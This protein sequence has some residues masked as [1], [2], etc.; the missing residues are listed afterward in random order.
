MDYMSSGSQLLGLG[1]SRLRFSRRLTHSDSMPS[2]PSSAQEPPDLLII[3]LG[4]ELQLTGVV[5]ILPEN[6]SVG[7]RLEAL[8]QERVD[9]LKG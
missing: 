8:L 6:L 5:K 2:E 7:R 9:V 1:W 3:R 4:L